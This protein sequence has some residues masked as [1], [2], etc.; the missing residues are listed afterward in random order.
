MTWDA[1]W[2]SIFCEGQFRCFYDKLYTADAFWEVQ[3]GI[4]YFT[5]VQS[6]YM[7]L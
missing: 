5:G 1:Q 3:V 2:L 6:A 7:I 4:M